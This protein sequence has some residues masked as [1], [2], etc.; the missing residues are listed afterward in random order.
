MQFHENPAVIAWWNARFGSILNWLTPTRRRLLL[1]IGALYVGI[2]K[3]LNLMGK[4]DELA[5]P[6]DMVGKLC[7]ILALFGI[8][9]LLYRAAVKFNSLPM[10]IRRHPQFTLHGLYWAFLGIIWLSAPVLSPWRTVLIGI[11]AVFPFII[12]RCGYLLQSGQ[13]GRMANTS[14]GD[15]LFYLWPVFGGTNTPYGKGHDYLSRFE[16]KTSDELAR[17]QLS[18]IKLLLLSV[19]WDFAIKLMN[20]SFYGADS[21]L[22]AQG[23]SG[24]PEMS[25]LVNQGANAPIAASWLSIYCE[26]LYQVLD[27]A[28]EGHRVVGA[29]RLFGFN[30]FRNTYKPL[31]AESIVEF[32][33]RYYYYF[34]EILAIFFFMPTFM[35]L[36]NLLKKLPNLRLF[37]AVF[38][39]AFVGNMYY[40]ILQKTD[41]LVNGEVFDAVYSLRSRFFYC[42][43]LAIGIFI[44]MYRAQQRNPVATDLW[45]RSVRMF[46]VWTF[47]SLIFIWNVKVKGG[48][49]FTTRIAFFL[50]LFGLA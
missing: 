39:A 7:V 48:G 49:D 22:A 46:G 35:K 50:N 32:W 2:K 20:M 27:H 45:S 36:G 23:G 31:L 4:Y 30:I 25:A 10:A 12:W 14:F 9:W 1:I 5:V 43:L 29:L 47:F 13:H 21:A 40:H 33:N 16:A 3:P 37:A 8:L 28:A 18:G 42:F 26:F 17:S 41:L 11:A 19:A 15:H 34:K 44:S 24:I 6:T 38:A